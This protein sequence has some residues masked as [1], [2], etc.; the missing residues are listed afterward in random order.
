MKFDHEPI[1]SSWLSLHAKPL[2]GIEL[3]ERTEKDENLREMLYRVKGCL[4]YIFAS[5]FCKSKKE[6]L[7][8]LEKCFLFHFKNSFRFRENHIFIF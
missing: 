6:H 2:G 1:F 5:L 7:W 4:R 3:K 8:N